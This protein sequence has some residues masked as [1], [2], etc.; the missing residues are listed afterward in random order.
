MIVFKKT[1]LLKT[2]PESASNLDSNIM[3]VR[4]TARVFGERVLDLDL[5]IHNLDMVTN[6]LK[7]CI[8]SSQSKKIVCFRTFTLLSTLPTP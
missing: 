4:E 6:E 8:F 5:P 1:I 3:I 7:I 2:C